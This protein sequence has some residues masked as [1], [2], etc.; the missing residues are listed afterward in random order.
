MTYGDLHLFDILIFGGIAAF[1]FFRLRSVLGKRT[2]FEKKHNPK[3]INQ[4]EEQRPSPTKISVPELDLKFKELETAY[5]KMK[6]FDH[7][8]FLEGAKIAFER[9]VLLFNQGDKQKLKPLLTNKTYDIFCKAI[10]LKKDK[11]NNQVLSLKIESVEKVQ[12]IGKKILIT[13][14]YLSSQID[15]TNNQQTQKKDIW[16]FEKNINSDNPNWLLS[17]T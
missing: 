5:K 2:G 6:N 17:S 9:I 8:K 15:P 7:L 4:E 11:S 13:I 16:T 1:L 14:A 3:I 10:D 12:I